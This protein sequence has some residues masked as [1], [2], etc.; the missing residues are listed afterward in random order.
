MKVLLYRD[1]S[2]GVTAKLLG[3]EPMEE[4]AELLGGMV[5]M[6]PLNERLMLVTQAD[7]EREGKPIWYALHRIG[8]EVEPISGECAI[9]GVGVEG[10]LRD[11]SV[12]DVYA[13]G[14]Y[15]NKVAAG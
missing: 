3:D 5:E 1:G 9:V 11:I 13:A 12:Q 8:R 15:I 6:A 10:R 2:A 14:C 7:A 4:L